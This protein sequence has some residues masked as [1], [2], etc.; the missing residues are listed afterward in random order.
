MDNGLIRHLWGCGDRLYIDYAIMR[1][2]LN[3]KEKEVLHLMLDECMTQE[4][5]AEEL[6]TSTRNVQKIWSCAVEKLLKI[7]WVQLYA[8]ALKEKREP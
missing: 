4:Q 1:A 5:T 2:N 6:D 7:E 3:R 8:L